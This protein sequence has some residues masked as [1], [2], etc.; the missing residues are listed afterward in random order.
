MRAQVLAQLEPCPPTLGTKWSC[1][2]VS[3]ASQG[4]G[5]R[6]PAWPTGCRPGASLGVNW[7]RCVVSNMEG[8]CRVRR[9]GGEGAAGAARR[10]CASSS[11]ELPK[12]VL[13]A[14]CAPL[15][16]SAP[17]PHRTQNTKHRTQDT[18]PRN[19]PATHSTPRHPHGHHSP[20]QQRTTTASPGLGARPP[21]GCPEGPHRRA[22]CSACSAP[23]TWSRSAGAT[24]AGKRVLPALCDT[25]LK[26]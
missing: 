23:G 25:L 2:V 3:E 17:A 16:P 13:Q 18:E 10:P 15:R 21:P 20:T 9:R 7:V 24:A 8:T 14:R 6:G 26:R 1:L 19:S 12:V 4:R 11:L 5:A 22:A